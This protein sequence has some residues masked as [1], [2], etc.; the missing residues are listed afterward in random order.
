[1]QVRLKQRDQREEVAFNAMLTFRAESLVQI[2]EWLQIKGTS[3]SNEF[4]APRLNEL[5]RFLIR[6][7]F[8]LRP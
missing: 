3:N 7:D 1:M 5:Q 4:L 2:N 6:P 8:S